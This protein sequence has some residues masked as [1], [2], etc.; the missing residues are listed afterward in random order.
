[1]LVM[2]FQRVKQGANLLGPL[3]TGA[4]LREGRDE[5]YL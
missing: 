4:K 1:V 3:Q 2:G 5:I